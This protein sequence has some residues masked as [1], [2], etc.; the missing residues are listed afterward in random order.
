MQDA[1]RLRDGQHTTTLDKVDH[2]DHTR[3]VT[4]A[5]GSE[6]G[7][8]EDEGVYQAPPAV[9]QGH[10]GHPKSSPKSR[11]S[12]DPSLDRTEPEADARD[13]AENLP[14]GL[15]GTGRYQCI[16]PNRSLTN[17]SGQD[18][19]LKNLMMSW[20]YAGY[21]TGLHQGQQQAKHL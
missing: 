18:K 2:H 8:V 4:D 15:L 19:A 7:E 3:G 9:Q 1:D 11:Q 21:Y 6:E 10:Y 17:L 20:Y 14:N 5:V 16:T 12:L 13:E